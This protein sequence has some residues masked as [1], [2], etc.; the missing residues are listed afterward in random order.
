MIITCNECDTRFNIDES[1][2]KQTGSKVRCSKCKNVFLA[3]PPS[4]SEEPNKSSGIETEL[5]DEE[6]ES[7]V[8]YKA[9]EKLEGIELELATYEA[10][11]KNTKV[12]EKPEKAG[13]EFELELDLDPEPEVNE[14]QAETEAELELELGDKTDSEIS[15]KE[16]PEE[17]EIDKETETKIKESKQEDIDQDKTLGD[18]T[19]EKIEDE[20]ESSKTFNMGVLLDEQEAEK[21][22]EP[23][24]KAE[25]GALTE[26]S[27]PP[28]VAAN[29]RIISMP[30]L[31]L[32]L[33]ALLIG[34]AYGTYVL[35]DSV[36]IDI[37][38]VS[39]LLKPEVQ[40]AGNLKIYTSDINNKFVENS[41]IGK[42]LVITGK[43]KNGYSD[44]R[45]YISITG[46]LYTKGKIL[47][48]TKTVYCGTIL[49]E[50]ELLNMDLDA[51]N[52]RLSN[53]FG[54]NKS[55]LKVKVDAII[56]FMVVFADFPE[57]IDEFT[58]EVAESFPS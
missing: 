36:G 31:L 7:G 43:A 9:E 53:R 57:N 32:L 16:E 4:L 48:K 12:E 58:V 11:K 19:A 52:N 44:A 22:I 26:K 50:L 27:E 29:K 24:D 6:I 33:A 35:L 51:I 42:L 3:Y 2:L 38:F 28:T 8:Q 49:S 30:V 39:D 15:A 45:S 20:E 18:H 17:I 14:T 25:Q 23:I 54:D 40:D 47:S 46:K 34:G 10:C 5:T 37:P 1:L 55:N 41:K 21:A 56:P 13:L